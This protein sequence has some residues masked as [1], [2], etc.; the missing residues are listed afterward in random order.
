MNPAIWVARQAMV[1]PDAPALADG[2]EVHA[3][4]SEFATRIAAVA[5][6][7]TNACGLVPGDRVA[8]VMGNSPEYLEA[9]FAIWHAGLVV[10][11]VNEIGRAHV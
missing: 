10:V 2:T 6:G 11:P 1:R 8:I 7:L 4:W 5:G 9:K 3:T